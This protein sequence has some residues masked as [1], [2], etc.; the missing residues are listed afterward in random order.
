MNRQRLDKIR[1]VTLVGTLVNLLLSVFK[2][3]AGILGHSQVVLA[4]GVH[5]ISDLA[6]DLA[7]LIGMNYWTE[8]PDDTHPY[9]HGH[10]ETLV[11]LALALTLAAV[12]LGMAFN[13]IASLKSHHDVV[14]GKI[15]LVAALT[16]LVSKEIL[17]RWTILVGR[18]EKSTAI[19][20]NAWHHRSDAF[21]SIPAVLAVAIAQIAPGWSFLD[22]VGAVLVSL[23]ILQAAWKIGHPA[24]Q[25]LTD[26]SAPP[27]TQDAMRALALAVPGVLASHALRT[28]FLGSGWGVDLHVQV[29]ADL[30]VD[31]GH[32]IAGAV[33]KRLLDDGP[34][35]V[36]VIVHVEPY[37]PAKAGGSRVK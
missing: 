16:S 11:T 25:A 35:V 7:V 31:K 28:R 27:E 26:R 9:G 2:V 23:L 12:S 4:D 24:L 20:A 1:R 6:T 21:S 22:H 10:I 15:A 33:K 17:F 30:T 18:Q 8:P 5:S 3:T 36:D 19:V 29:Q 14:P 34:D 37:E 13:A 32:N